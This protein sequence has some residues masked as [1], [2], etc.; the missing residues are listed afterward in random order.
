VSS[1]DRLTAGRDV[2]AEIHV[3]VEIPKGSQNKY[4]Y[5]EDLGML[6]LDRVLYSPMVYPGDYGFVPKTR[7]SDGDPLDALVLVTYPTYPGTLVTARPV[8]V[9]EMV[10]GGVEDDKVLCVPVGDPRFDR[11][12]DIGDIDAHHQDEIAHF[13]TV[14][15]QL[16]GKKVEVIGWRDAAE[17]HRIIREAVVRY[18]A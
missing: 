18:A 10:D 15:K 12:R 6:R 17:A 14:Y 8:G 1:L 3:L 4:E 2:P 9:L 7:S 16:E 5:D 13:F 11:T